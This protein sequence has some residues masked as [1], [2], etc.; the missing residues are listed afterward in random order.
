MNTAVMP[1]G[2]LTEQEVLAVLRAADTAPSLCD[3]PPWR[4]RC[5]ATAVELSSDPDRATPAADP[6]RRDLLLACG[7]ALLNLRLAIRGLGAHPA[8]RLAPD[9]DRPD[10]LASV[11]PQGRAP[12][13]P[14]DRGMA[15]AVSRRRTHRGPFDGTALPAPLLNGLRQAARIEQ[16]WLATLTSTQVAALR[17]LLGQGHDDQRHEPA[18]VT[19]WSQWAPGGSPPGP[20][21]Q[22][23]T[24]S[25]D[26]GG[27]PPPAP[28]ADGTDPLVAVIG[29]FHDV[30]TAWLQAGQA[31]QR[32]LL[33][34]TMAG[35]SASFLSPAVRSPTTRTRL[36]E[37]IG[38]GLWPQTVLRLGYGSPALLVENA[39]D[40]EQTLTHC[41]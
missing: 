27:R 26:P 37:L 7:A 16:A 17:I 15:T 4:F 34:A 32:V 25:R 33:T 13:S 31:M 29:S 2:S 3:S 8:V 41:A 38:G 24:G 14:T 12:V 23:G 35:V 19:E 20:P 28:T 1:V 9:P 11:R 6:D 21:D 36:R 10:V 39:A 40:H 30:P 22:F 18:S 5:T